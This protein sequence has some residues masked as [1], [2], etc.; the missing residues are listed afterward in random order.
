MPH[1]KSKQDGDGRGT[2]PGATKGRS[3]VGIRLVG[4]TPGTCGSSCHRLTGLLGWLLASPP[5]PS[6][7]ALRTS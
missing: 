6:A 2:V 5:P 7:Q 4:G 1:S 3:H